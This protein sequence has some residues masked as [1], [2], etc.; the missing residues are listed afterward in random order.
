VRS[1]PQLTCGIP[2]GG[3]D[4]VTNVFVL[5]QRFDFATFDSA[6][7]IPTRSGVGERMRPVILSNIANSRSTTGLFGAGYIEMLAR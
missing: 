3:G 2:G 1:V 7:K 6:D 5:G 4:Y